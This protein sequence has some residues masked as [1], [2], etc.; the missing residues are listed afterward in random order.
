MTTKLL[1]RFD[2]ITGKTISMPIFLQ[3]F[4]TYDKTQFNIISFNPTAID[5]R[6]LST[7]CLQIGKNDISHLINTHD[8]RSE[9]DYGKH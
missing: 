1:N 4:N 5:V 3:C 9:L 8:H 6:P 7:L 2:D